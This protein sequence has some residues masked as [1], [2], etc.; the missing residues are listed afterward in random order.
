MNNTVEPWDDAR[1]PPGHRHGHRPPAHRRQL[2]PARLD[3][4]RPSS[5]PARIP[6]RLRRRCVLRLR[7]GGRQGAAGRG[8]LSGRLQTKIQLRDASTVPTSP[9]SRRSPRRS[10][11][12]SRTNLN[13]DA[14]HRRSR[15]RAPSWTTTRPAS[16]TASS[17]S[18]GAPTIPTPTNFLDYHF[19][20]GAGLKFGDAVPGPRRRPQPGRPDARRRRAAH[21]AL[22]A[23]PTTSSSE[24]VPVRPIAHGGSADVFKADV[25]GAHS[26]RS[27]PSSSRHEA[28]RPR[29]PGVD[30]ERRAAQPL[31]RA[32]RPTARPCAPAS[33]SR[34]P[35]TRYEVGGTAPMPSA[36][37]R[38]H[39]ERGPHGL[40]LHA[41]RGRHVPRWLDARCLRRHPLVSPPSGM[42]SSPLHVGPVRCLR[43]LAGA[44]G[45]GFLNPPGPAACLN[46]HPCD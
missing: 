39:A 5:R 16:W 41:A 25:E 22:H 33:R 21:R 24:Y 35:S 30:A 45:G 32:T 9:R 29:H 28:R 17:C 3:G 4:R 31:L 10:R 34:N 46:P 12:S 11:P 2:L 19:G 23:R 43:V 8:R 37:H 1:G 27:T 13:I 14:D 15:S 40:D 7:P 26:R 36:G 20:S 6:L 42:P 44:V 18:A 38:V